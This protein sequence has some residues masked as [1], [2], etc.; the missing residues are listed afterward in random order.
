MAI[1]DKKPGMLALIG[2]EFERY[3]ALGD[4]VLRLAEDVADARDMDRKEVDRVATRTRKQVG[5][6]MAVLGIASVLPEEIYRSFAAIS[7]EDAILLNPHGLSQVAQDLI[8]FLDELSHNKD[9][10]CDSMFREVGRRF[11]T[12]V[13]TI[14]GVIE[15]AKSQ[16]NEGVL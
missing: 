7:K 11:C 10:P 14:R 5:E 8:L 12:M 6:T 2:P 15:E 13:H 3:S 1:E 4:D 9:A 16:R